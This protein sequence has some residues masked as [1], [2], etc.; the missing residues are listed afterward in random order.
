MKNRLLPSAPERGQS[1]LAP[2]ASSGLAALWAPFAPRRFLAPIEAD[3]LAWRDERA[4]ASARVV[5][6]TAT[7]SFLVFALWDYSVAPPQWIPLLPVRGAFWHAA[8]D[9]AIRA[10]C[11]TTRGALRSSDSLGRIG[12]EEFAVLLP[13]TDLEAAVVLAERLRAAIEGVELRSPAGQ[14]FRFFVSIGVA[15]ARESDSFES[16]LQRA[17]AALYEAKDAGRN[18]VV[19]G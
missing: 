16:L 19:V 1:R 14:P 2:P 12:G 6:L 8:G 9:D 17:A 7:I 10:L 4:L 13:E 18:R 15:G 3:Y 5:L 11:A